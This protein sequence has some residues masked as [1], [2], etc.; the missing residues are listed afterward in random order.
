VPKTAIHT[1]T[2]AKPAGVFS[3]AT[4]ASITP[5]TGRLVFVSGLTARDP[6]TG[7]TVGVGDVRAQTRTILDAMTRVLAEASGTLDDVTRVTVYVTDIE[8]DFAAIHEVRA[9]Y[10]RAP[11]PASTM[12]EVSRLVSPDM[13]IEIEAIAIVDSVAG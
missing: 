10:F 1:D 2:L 11:L 5:N 3:Q 4:V 8:R 12:V 6:A 7:A 13:L 9:Q